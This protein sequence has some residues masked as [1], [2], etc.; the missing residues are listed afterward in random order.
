MSTR[1]EAARPPVESVLDRQALGAAAYPQVNLLPPEIRSNRALGRVKGR[2]GI[3]LLATLLAAGMGYAYA[4]IEQSAANADLRAAQDTV[5]RLQE[6]QQQYAE[7]PQVKSQIGAVKASLV[8][9]TSAEV[10]W[11]PYIQAIQAVAPEGWML[12]SFQ[13]AM[14]TPMAPGSVTADPLATPGVGTISFEGRATT[15]SDVAAWL[16]ALDSIPGF[17]GA[18][19]SSSTLAD[20]QGVAYLQTSV[21]VQVD[22]AAFAHRFADKE[23]K[24]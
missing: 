14:P 13:T 9:G 10:M 22:A 23:A 11:R 3:L 5:T 12:T 4:Q 8:F 20:E 16:D 1:T 24:G 2:L 21:T 18:T 6:Q 15:V 19:Y 17:F 7:V